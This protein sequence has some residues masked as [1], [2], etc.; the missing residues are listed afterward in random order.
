MCDQLVELR[1]EIK[2]CD[3]TPLLRLQERESVYN[4]EL[5]ALKTFGVAITA[6]IDS[7]NMVPSLFQDL[8]L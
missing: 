6:Q 5:T 3:V 4:K 8:N 1:V 7:L 2:A